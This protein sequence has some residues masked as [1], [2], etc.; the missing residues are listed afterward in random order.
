MVCNRCIKVV[1]EEL[2]KLG[3]EI[4]KI[5]L[6]KVELTNL[7]GSVSLETIDKILKENG[8]EL[9]DD[10]KSRLVEQIKTIV[11]EYIHHKKEKP[12]HINSSDFLSKKMGYD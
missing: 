12:E 9:I 5:E 8:F 7:P 11:I 3:L 6:G 10:K 4:K 1:A 2:T